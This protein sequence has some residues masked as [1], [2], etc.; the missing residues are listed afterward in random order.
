M[1]QFRSRV[2]AS[3]ALAQLSLGA[4]AATVSSPLNLGSFASTQ[5]ATIVNGGEAETGYTVS[6]AGDINGD[7][8]PD[9]IVTTF[10]FL[11]LSGGQGV[12]QINVSSIYVVFGQ[13]GGFPSGVD[14]SALNGSNGFRVY[15]EGTIND[16]A[17]YEAGYSLSAAGDVNGDGIAD[18]IIGVPGHGYYL[19][20]DGHGD[21]MY[22][23]GPGAAFVIFGHNGAF[24][25]TIDPVTDLDGNNGFT[26][27]GEANGDLAGSCVSA[28]GDVNGDG[29]ADLIIGAPGAASGAGAA[30]V[31][32]GHAGP[33]PVTL[34]LS[35]SDG[36][37]GFK[38]AGN[39]AGDQFGTS[40]SS[41]D[42]FQGL[43]LSNSYLLIGAPGAGSGAGA[44]YVV[45]GQS[46]SA[47]TPSFGIGAT[48]LVT[49]TGVSAGDQLGYSVSGVGDL[50]GDGLGDLI[51]G[52][53]G[54]SGS[55]GAAYVLFGE[56]N[57]RG[58]VFPHML[59]PG[60]LGVTING[61]AVGDQAGYCVGGAGDV[62]GDGL[63]DLII[64]APGASTKAGAAYVIFGP[65]GSNNS[66][67]A[68]SSLT[69][70]NGFKIAGV[71]NGDSTGFS[72]SG[73]GDV[74]GD[75]YDDVI[76]GAP[77]ANDSE[78]AAFVIYGGPSGVTVGPFA[79]HL[80]DGVATFTDVDGDLVTVK[81]KTQVQASSFDMLVKSLDG[82]SQCLEL[83]IG[84]EFE[85]SDLSIT[86]KRANGGD[87]KVNIGF[88]N[89]AGV[90]LGHMTVQGDLGKIVA[91][92]GGAAMALKSLTV[93][94]LGAFG[95]LTEDT[96]SDHTS[97]IT[98]T[99]GA[100]KVAGDV[101]E[102]SLI[103]HDTATAGTGKA[104]SVTIGGSLI[105][106]AAI[107]SGDLG[108]DTALGVVSI[109]GDIVGGS[110]QYSG[111][112]GTNSFTSLGITSLHVGGSLIGGSGD[113]SGAVFPGGSLGN[114][115]IVGDQLG[116]AGGGSGAIL[117]GSDTT[118]GSM[119]KISIEGSQMGGIGVESALI[120]ADGPGS[121]IASVTIG[122][123]ARSGEPMPGGLDFA[124][125]II[126]GGELGPVVIKGSIVGLAGNPYVI[127]GVGALA[128]RTSVAMASLT[129]DG[130]FEHALVLAGF[131]PGN[132]G[133]NGHA[134]I[135]AITVGRDWIASSVTAGATDSAGGFNLLGAGGERLIVNAADTSTA[136]SSIGHIVI[137]GDAMGSF[138]P[139]E[140]YG[141]VA[142]E[143]GSVTV[144]GVKL[145][146]QP[147]PSNDT[148]GLQI[149]PTAN[150]TLR[151]VAP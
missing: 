120:Y 45:S 8:I 37:N 105:G 4:P 106:G 66:T 80:N 21:T 100:I 39:A 149:G 3:L 97:S 13:P 31:L 114:V 47:S 101:R 10:Q 127:R 91:G 50:N 33:F 124:G 54:V 2:I 19:T 141:I 65:A 79:L 6:S 30:Y 140:R 128:G 121:N 142:E 146:L 129:V 135:E 28:A 125:G 63:S 89:A 103:V 75:G 56:P 24:P 23:P 136:L 139:G 68:L 151:E 40:V 83:T 131:G 78:G 32:F 147:G 18:L 69:G 134:Q 41:L 55:T 57:G 133:V 61:E 74:N 138:V 150:F 27:V 71:A 46:L 109:G 102:A 132:A 76:V 34:N 86:V 112:V 88:I 38:I 116:G 60:F 137:K 1:H 90:D 52:A 14:L 107:A 111:M 93:E 95:G 29:F 20:S 130:N 36:T 122:G 62:N 51:V 72:V 126:A 73:A 117:S 64:G 48:A 115:T 44:A 9:F 58:E 98:G 123:D 113:L 94:S 42:D 67:L 143:I 7:G 82:R 148:G 118:K 87:G 144:G 5:G 77:N 108:A 85:G 26:I 17:A 15:H 84:H 145:T 119:G 25:A 11:Q 99:V 35:G 110:G 96:G 49:M 53:P 70:A 22:A 104:A 16:S 59:T 81:L 43:G 92:G 12:G